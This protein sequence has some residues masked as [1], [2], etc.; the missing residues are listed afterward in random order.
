MAIWVCTFRSYFLRSLVQCCE[1]QAKTM[2]ACNECFLGHLEFHS[3]CCSSLRVHLKHHSKSS[4]RQMR[5][6]VCTEWVIPT[7][8]L[9]SLELFVRWPLKHGTA[10]R[11]TLL[12]NAPTHFCLHLSSGEMIF[13]SVHDCPISYPC[14]FF[15]FFS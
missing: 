8:V 4:S 1:M 7:L 6:G 15:N 11:S 12:P 5:G 10:D 9:V 3:Y 14:G 13:Y 2:F